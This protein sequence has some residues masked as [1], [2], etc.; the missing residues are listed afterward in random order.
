M[1]SLSKKIFAC[2][3]AMVAAHASALDKHTAHWS[4]TGHADASHWGDMAAEYASCKLG[5]DQSPIDIETAKAVPAKLDAIDFRYASGPA[6]VVNNGH[7]IQ[8]N[9]AP[10]NRIAIGGAQ[11]DLLQ[12]HFHTPSEEHV[13]GQPFPMVAHFVHRDAEGK[14]AVVGVLLKEGKENRSLKGVFA[15]MPAKEGASVKLKRL[16][17]PSLLPANRGYY[18]YMGSLTTPP[19]SEGVRWQV[20]KEPVELSASQ[21]NAFK[22]IYALNARPVQ[23]TNGRVVQASE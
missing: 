11:Y 13:D 3:A 14:L 18:A 20:L 6:Q 7:T 22:K 8:V 1:H 15:G 4:Y 2:L 10:G 19:C 17:L 23:P 12:F 5:K 16:A 9:L 21:I